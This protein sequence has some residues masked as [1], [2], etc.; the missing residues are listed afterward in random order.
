[1]NFAEGEGSK[2]YCIRAKH[3][4]VLCAVVVGVGLTVGLAV[5]L[6]RSCGSTG[7]GG[8]GTAPAPSH[9][10]SS[11]ASPSGPPAQDQGICPA[12]EDETGE[13]KHFRLPDSVNPVHYDL[14]VKPL[15]EED[16][17][18]GTVS[19]SINLSA[20]TRHLWL[21][22]RET[23]ITQLPVLKRPSGDQ[24]P[25]RRCFEYK[26]QEYVVLEA[27]EELTPSSGDGLYLLTMEFA[28]WLNGSLVGFYRTTYT[29]NGQMGL[30][31]DGQAG[32]ELLT[33]G[34]PPTSASQSARIT[35]TGFHHVG[36][37]GL[38][39]L[40]SGDPPALASK[41][42]GLQADEVSPC[43]PGWSSPC[44]SPTSAS[45]SAEITGLSHCAQLHMESC[46]VTQAGVQWHDLG[47]LQPLPPKFKRFSCL[48]LPSSWDYRHVPS[49][50]AKYVL[51]VDMKFHYLGQAGLE[52]LTLSIA[53]T[54]HEP[55]DARKSFPCFDEPNKKATYTISITHPKEYGA[56]SNM[57]VAKEESV[58]DQWNRTTFEKSVPMSTYLSRSI[59]RLG[60]VAQSRLTA[61]SVFR[62]QAFSCLSLPS[63]WDYRHAPPRPA[64]FLYFSRDGVSPC[65]P[66]WSRSL[67][68]MGFHHD[69]QAGLELLT[70]VTRNADQN[71]SVEIRGAFL[72]GGLLSGFPLQSLFQ[73]AEWTALPSQS[74]KHH[75]KGDPVPFTLHQELLGQGTGKTAAP[76]KRVAL[77]TCGTPPLGMSSSVGAKNSSVLSFFALAKRVTLATR[78]A[79]PPG[80]SETGFHHVGQDG[81]DLLTS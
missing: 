42:L 19:I 75:P 18:T 23:R 48:S 29:E 16:T 56:L 8:A 73:S 62:F 27:E 25:V 9:Q 64:N 63:S 67:D 2:R 58:D 68:L 21:H 22:L 74:S 66:G 24:V 33:S 6:T 14:H 71:S 55:T 81:L 44:D 51:L 37:A 76:A 80:I 4:A 28:G 38:E 49:C 72:P 52:L 39:L 43:W 5:G 15:L 31:H 53:A 17:Y 69:S 65:W 54:D 20:P 50:L 1:M 7:D 46:S 11:T 36:Q 35:G 32:L 26:P 12:S 40:T 3:V 30:H 70:S 10:P 57:P 59:A 77:V 47:S 13:W 41:V 78:V 60:A 45:Q 34:D 79:P 61:L